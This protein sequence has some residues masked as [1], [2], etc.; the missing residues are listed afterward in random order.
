MNRRFFAEFL[1]VLSRRVNPDPEI[2]EEEEELENMSI[3]PPLPASAMP[4]NLSINS[5]E[6]KNL[7]KPGVNNKFG[8]RNMSMISL[9]SKVFDLTF[10]Q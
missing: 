9:H 3:C 1:T 2:I 4:S 8:K 6:K 7:L 10:D 5:P